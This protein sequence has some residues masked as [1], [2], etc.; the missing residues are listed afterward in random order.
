MAFPTFT[1]GDVLTATDMNAV[2]LW[3]VKTQSVGTGVSTVEVTNA[4]SS[5]YRNYY[6]TWTGGTLNAA[7]NIA[8]Y[9]GNA[10]LASGYYGARVAAN[11]SGTSLLAGD[12]NANSW[13]NAAAGH[14]AGA[15]CEFWFFNP[16]IADETFFRSTFWKINTADPI[17]GD[18]TGFLNN[19][20][21]YTSF[22][23]DPGDATTMS[24]GTIRVYGYRN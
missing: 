18:Y 11:P 1:S 5:T 22:T 9:M 12:N 20:T 16:N 4:F 24:G 13:N 8:V 23:L 19:T 15:T 17:F 21:Q 7:D 10:T 3:L 6:V 14:T 2:G